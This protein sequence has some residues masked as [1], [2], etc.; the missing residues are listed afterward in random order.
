MKGEGADGGKD[1]GWI[2]WGKVQYLLKKNIKRKQFERLKFTRCKTAES[3]RK[4]CF[5]GGVKPVWLC[6]WSPGPVNQACE[7]RCDHPSCFVIDRRS[8]QLES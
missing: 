6:D 3:E 2:R 8:C 5:P 1:D 4:S 7:V